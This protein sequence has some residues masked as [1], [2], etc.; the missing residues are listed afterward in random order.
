M[1]LAK[2]DV[3]LLDSWHLDKRV[4]VS[5]I[6]MLAVQIGGGVSGLVSGLFFE[7][8][9]VAPYAAPG[10]QKVSRAETIAISAAV[11]AAIG[12]GIDVLHHRR[13]YRGARPGPTTRVLLAPVVTPTAVSFR[14]SL[15]R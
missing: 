10:C 5:I 12:A 4:N 14:V 9:C 1:A 7:E 11:G 3:N 2:H 13:V 15:L 6:I 8:S